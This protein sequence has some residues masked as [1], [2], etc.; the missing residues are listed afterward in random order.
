MYPYQQQYQPMHRSYYSMAQPV[1][2]PAPTVPAPAPAPSAPGAMSPGLRTAEK[3]LG[4][5]FSGAVAYTGIT[6]GMKAKG[7]KSAA[8]WVAGVG[9]AVLGVAT[10]TSFASPSFASKINPFR[11]A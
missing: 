9:G 1:P 5:V 10:L 2:P 8:G 3:A 11:F 4:L 7:I 6:V